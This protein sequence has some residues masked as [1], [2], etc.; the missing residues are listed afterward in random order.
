MIN[1]FIQKIYVL[2]TVQIIK[3]LKNYQLQIRN[4]AMIAISHVKVVMELK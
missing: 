1:C 4:Y 2:I 3:L